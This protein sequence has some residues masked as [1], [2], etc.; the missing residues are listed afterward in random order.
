MSPT[1]EPM[2]RA[3]IS[4]GAH[5]AGDG[6]TAESAESAEGGRRRLGVPLWYDWLVMS[7]TFVPSRTV[8]SVAAA[9]S[10][11]MDTALGRT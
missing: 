5:G 10:S 9:M 11:R 4:D 2:G 3:S 8:S 7:L 6:L 1:R